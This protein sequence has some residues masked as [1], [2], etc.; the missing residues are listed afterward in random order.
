MSKPRIIIADSNIAYLIPLQLKVASEL[1][2]RVDI[3]IITDK[4]Y[5]DDLFS[6]SQTADA[7]V[8]SEEFYTPD[9]NKHNIGSIFLLTESA[10][11]SD[12][13]DNNV[14]KIFKYTSVN[15][16]FNVISSNVDSSTGL[17]GEIHSTKVVVVTSASGGVGKTT[18]SLG[19]SGALSNNYKKV[20]YLEA[21]S[22][23]M[24]QI[25][26][27]NQTPIT[28]SEV[29]EKIND[30]KTNLVNL[31]KHSIRK[32]NF[33]YLPPFKGAC[34][35]LGIEQGAFARFVSEMKACNDYDYIV[36]DIQGDFN[37]T[38]ADMLSIADKVIYIAKQN[39]TSVCAT[40]IFLDCIA[41]YAP[42]KYIFICNDYDESVNNYLV[43]P[44][45]NCGFSISEYIEHI[46]NFEDL[47]IDDVAKQSS[48]AKAS[49]LVL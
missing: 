1:F 30:V 14:Q 37:E 33:Y 36:V 34:L 44:E 9:L 32:E 43:S 8:V 42:E 48:I 47:S 26:M 15:D 19:I 49:L 4:E 18:L 12:V 2:N 13:E 35:S 41:D 25:Y 40:N 39:K 23:Q 17:T 46:Y 22:L 20:L 21:S 28:S 29:Y 7:L 27:N 10:D 31:L 38:L 45:M 5:F 16:I 6:T 3:E 24:F 11:D